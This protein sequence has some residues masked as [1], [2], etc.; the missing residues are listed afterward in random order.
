[1][2]IVDLQ[3]GTPEWHAW[4]AG[5]IGGSDMPVLFGVSRFKT[6]HQL[7]LEK[8]GLAKSDD[9]KNAYIKAKGHEREIELRA[10]ASDIL[11]EPLAVTCLQG[12]LP[13][14]RVSVDGI[15]SD[16]RIIV[17]AK[18]MKREDF[19]ALRDHKIVPAEYRPQLAHQVVT[20]GAGACLFVGKNDA[21]DEK[22]HYLVPRQELEDLD[23]VE[24]GNAFWKLVED[25]EEPEPDES[26]IIT[27][28]NEE[29]R[30]LANRFRM[31]KLQIAKYEK[32]QEEVAAQ[33]K[34][35]AGEARKARCGDVT[36]TR[37]FKKGNVDYKKIPQL[38]GVDLEAFRKK[39]AFQTRIDV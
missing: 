35:L 37:F 18:L 20:S 19:I 1:M 39:G 36:L 21:L 4:R 7:W 23:T 11:E 29:V 33:L 10:Y 31:A 24:R 32:E 12:D 15:T 27:L 16:A 28:D 13:W 3:Q 14:Q 6:K 25:G 17:E 5:G 30:A 34:A 2:N 22:A 26:E 38:A 8:Q 9:G